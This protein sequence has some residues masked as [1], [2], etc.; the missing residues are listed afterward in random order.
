[1]DGSTWQP[2]ASAYVSHQVCLPVQNLPGQ[3]EATVVWQM[4]DIMSKAM[5]HKTRPERDSLLDQNLVRLL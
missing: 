1:M 4:P 2:L 3:M 5:P